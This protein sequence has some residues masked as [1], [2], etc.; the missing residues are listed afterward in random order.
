MR[1]IKRVIHLLALEV[2][3]RHGAQLFLKSNRHLK[4]L[5]VIG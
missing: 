1:I 3:L 5:G 4:I 2:D